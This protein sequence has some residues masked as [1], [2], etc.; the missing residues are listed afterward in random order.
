MKDRIKDTLLNGQKR[1]EKKHLVGFEPTTS[2]L[3]GMCSTAVLQPHPFYAELCFCEQVSNKLMEASEVVTKLVQDGIEPMTS[4]STL[5]P[6]QQPARQV[7]KDVKENFIKTSWVRIPASKLYRPDEITQPKDISE[8]ER[9][10]RLPGFERTTAKN[11]TTSGTSNL[12][13]INVTIVNT[14][15]QYLC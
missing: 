13:N 3:R 9:H 4:R 15:L 1:E 6:R 14:I 7:K 12:L 10:G 2:L 11:H 5:Q 8:M